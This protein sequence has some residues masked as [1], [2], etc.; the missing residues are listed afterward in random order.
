[1]TLCQSHLLIILSKNT[2]GPAS[3]I[4]FHTIINQ[5]LSMRKSDVLHNLHSVLI[6]QQLHIIFHIYAVLHV[7]YIYS[8]YYK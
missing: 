8:E 2:L 5:T 6:I 4:L 3:A 7:Q 1:M